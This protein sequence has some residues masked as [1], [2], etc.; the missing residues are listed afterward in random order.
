[1]D[2]ELRDDT[3]EK[4]KTG[5]G[6]RWCINGAGT[7]DGW[8]VSV[9]D[10]WPGNVKKIKDDYHAEVMDGDRYTTWF[11]TV[12]LPATRAIDPRGIIVVDRASYHLLLTEDSKSPQSNWG[13]QKLVQYCIDNNAVDDQ[14]GQK[15]SWED[16]YGVVPIG[17]KQRKN[18]KTMKEI[19]AI[20]R[21][22]HSKRTKRYKYQDWLREFNEKHGSDIKGLA[23][24]AAHPR[25]NPIERCWGRCKNYVASNNRTFTMEAVKELFMD[26][27]HIMDEEKFWQQSF[28]S[29]LEEMKL[30]EKADNITTQ[31][32]ETDD[33]DIDD[34]VDDSLDESGDNSSSNGD[35]S[36]DDEDL[37]DRIPSRVCSPPRMQLRIRSKTRNPNLD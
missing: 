15:Y 7:K 28:D 8:L 9:F 22:A 5:R 24:P 23:L 35:V 29:M 26:M 31:E 6:R 10:I 37:D 36:N 19:V 11:K 2:P 32:D 14:T 4:Y 25:L 17:K 27:V 12:L 18:G 3:M 30:Y 20:A 33:S 21:A 16:L 13:L 1:M 34:V